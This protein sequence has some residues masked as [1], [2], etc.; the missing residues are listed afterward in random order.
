MKI[1]FK[2]LRIV[3]LFF[4]ILMFFSSSLFSQ[5]RNGRIM[6]YV[7][8]SDNE[9]LSYAS[10][11][12][13]DTKYGD[14][15]ADDGR[16]SFQAPAGKY[17]L[18]V[19]YTGYITIEKEVVVVSG[20]S[21]DV[22]TLI[23]NADSKRLREVVVADIQKNKFSKKMTATVARMPLADMENPSAY[24]VVSKDF[25]QEIV[26]TDLN[27][28]VSNVPGVIAN[29]GVNDS[30]NDFTLRGFTS[31]ATFRN[32]LI[33]N[34]RTQTE[35]AN[36]ERIEILK[37]PAG[38][39]FGGLM[40]TYGGV[41]N[42]VTKRPYESFR[43]DVNYTTGS[44]GLNRFTVDLNTPLNKDRTALA[45]FNGVAHT[46]NSFQ[47]AGYMKSLAF[48]ASLA[49]K[50]SERTTVRFDADIYTPD[51]T[52]NA[53]V[54]NSQLLNYESMKDLKSSHGR[55]FTSNDIGTKRTSYYA[56]AEVEHRISN[57]WTSRT[58]YQHGESGEKESIF[59]VLMYNTD[60]TKVSRYIRPFD[61][62][63]M[64][65]DNFQQNFIGEF[66]LGKIRNRFVGGFDILARSTFYQ[67]GTF[68]DNTYSRVFVFYDDVTLDDTTPWQP[69]T[70]TE[71][72]K[73]ERISTTGI[74]NSDYSI[75]AYA[76]DVIDF[77][78]WLVAMASVR[79][80][81][82]KNQKT[83]TN[84]VKGDDDYHQVQVSPKF[85]IVAKL[86]KDKISLFGNY[87]NGFTNVAPSMGS[88][89]EIRKWD[90]QQSYQAEGG[91][92][93]ELLDGK[94]TST[95]S[96]YDIKVKNLVRTLDDGTSEQDGTQYSRGF[97]AEVIANP[98]R[99]L[100]I[101][102]GFGTNKN[103]YTR[104][105]ESYQNKKMY[106]IPENIF[107]LW[108][109][110]KILD[111]KVEGL[112]FGAGVNYV[113][114]ANLNMVNDFY[115]PDYTLLSASLFY[116]QPKYKVTLKVNNLTDVTYWS[117][118]GQP[119]NPRQFMANISYKF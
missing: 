107:S 16:F 23:I 25:M 50:T 62:Y 40:S 14:M 35:I 98:V 6:G 116:D 9:P 94:I 22:G 29:N 68:K 57:N 37:G 103:K 47:D 109:S 104:Y 60:N 83:V 11:L 26:A 73:L 76:S 85:G 69:I 4:S 7:K 12:L 108:T 15:A 24:S 36:V 31:N 46:Q 119:Q 28:A 102:A 90:P 115:V 13:Q 49:F 70:R 84:G 79:V 114:K 18:I 27:S 52:L 56:L 44:W 87:S 8:T 99:G 75:S 82:Y 42:T 92:K 10:V 51:K 33:V 93:F 77:T 100:N 53:Y 66:N 39:L 72:N 111:G 96:Y 2:D 88:N 17:T 41:V 67:Y 89:G 117:V 30:G 21:L 1:G 61:V 97:E 58:S 45:R 110:Y 86:W 20:Q 32:G 48:A 59:I 78:D 101:V 105:N 3:I 106:F 5:S 91:F 54:R 112:G 38:T 80:D 63:E 64:K 74:K 113:G 71:V 34:P 118:Y 55:A 19:T 43:G 65:T 81:R 95:I